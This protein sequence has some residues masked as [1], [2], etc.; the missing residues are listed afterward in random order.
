MLAAISAR[1]TARSL[2]VADDRFRIVLLERNSRPGAKIAI[3][4]GGHCNI[5]HDGPVDQLLEKGF[6]RK[7]EQRFVRHSVYRFTNGDLLALLGRY[8]VTTVTREDGR[9]F[10]ASGRAGDVLDAF[11]RMVTDSSAE[12]ITGTRVD[13]LD[14]SSQ[15]FTVRAGSSSFNADSVILAA[16]GASWGSA[17]TTGDG[18][19]L[20]AAA[21]H[22]AAQTMPAL[23]PIFFTVAPKTELV[24][25]SLRG[26]ELVVESGSDSDAKRGDVLISHRGVSGPACLSLSRSV[27]EFLAS[28]RGA[29]RI[30][31]D[32][33]PGHD[34]AA[35]SAFV[36]DHAARH[37]SQMVRTFLQRCPLAPGRLTAD[38]EATAPASTIPNAFAV[39]IMR[40]AEIADGQV[41][42]GL[43]R[44]QRRALVSILKRMPLGNVR[45]VPLDKAEVSA[46]GV[47]LSEIDPKSMESRLHPR[48]YCC[49]E[50]LDYAGEVG[51]FNLQAAFSTGWT[52][53]M[54]ATLNLLE[55]KSP[56]T[57]QE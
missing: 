17:G 2:G 31:V 6:L 21:G 45:K 11:R 39:E 54:H 23:A 1:R 46:G 47:S 36:L 29:V 20:A 34:E 9:V 51:G 49:G 40:L 13:G 44:E 33:F 27:A 50:M 37:G 52:A 3:S 26:I 18:I 32:L 56:Q 16:G 15:G 12:I 4:G 55:A 41:M 14:I 30:M 42:S 22:R 57:A 5:T 48:L 28:G 43:T 7:S 24:G 35:I 19:R 38:A 10:P 8:G 25:V 53:G